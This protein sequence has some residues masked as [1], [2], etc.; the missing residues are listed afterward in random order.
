M[1]IY[2]VRKLYR[3]SQAIQRSHWLRSFPNATFFG[4]FGNGVMD[5]RPIRSVF[6]NHY[7]YIICAVSLQQVQV[8]QRRMRVA[9]LQES[10]CGQQGAVVICIICI[11]IV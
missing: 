11:I 8:M 4:P 5:V 7:V 1:S 2:P 6:F 3:V 10:R 9:I